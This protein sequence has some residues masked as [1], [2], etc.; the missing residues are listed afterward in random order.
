LLLLLDDPTAIGL[1]PA[2]TGEPCAA[3]DVH[4]ELEREVDAVGVAGVSNRV[5]EGI[6]VGC[7]NLDP[8]SQR[9]VLSAT[10]SRRILRGSG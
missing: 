9:S 6:V 3:G 10:I 7:P 1:E 8:Q 2:T 5:D 4:R